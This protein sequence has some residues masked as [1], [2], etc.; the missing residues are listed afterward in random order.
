MCIRQ[1]QDRFS[2]RRPGG[3]WWYAV[4]VATFVLGV[5]C[6]GIASAAGP[7]WRPV[8]GQM[9][10]RWAKEVTPET[11][12]PE[13]PRPMMV[14]GQW[15]NLNGLWE[16]AM[17]PVDEKQRPDRFD[18]RILVPFGVESALSGVKKKVVETDR[19]WYRRT[20][21]VPDVWTG[22]RI[23][24]NF[25]AVDWETTIWVNGNEATHHRGGY[26]PFSVDI[27]D[28]LRASGPQEI[29]A[30]VWDPTDKGHQMRGKQQIIPEGFMYTPTSGIWQ[31][32]W[33]EP[34]SSSYIRSVYTEPDIDENC[35]WVTVDTVNTDDAFTV[36]TTTLLPGPGEMEGTMPV[37]VE[38]RAGQRLRIAL[39]DEPE[40]R[41]WSPR[42]PFLYD[43][44]VILKDRTGKPI[45]MV[46]SYFGMRKIAVGKD[47]HDVNRLFLNNK[48]LFQFGFLDQGW[49]PDGLYTAPTDEALRYDIETAKRL[50]ANMVRKHV[51]FEPQRFYYWCDKLGILVWQDMPSGV[52]SDK[53]KRQ[54]ELE[55]KRM[56]DA[57]RSHP[58]IVM[59]LPFN[60]GWG[61]FDAPR[62][63][64]WIKHYDPTRLVNHASGWAD[65]GDF[66]DVRDI[67]LYPE[68]GVAPILPN[69]AIVLGE[70]GGISMNVKGHL[71]GEEDGWGYS[72]IGD[73]PDLTNTYVRQINLLRP[74]I[75]AGLSAACYTQIADQEIECNGVMTYDREVLKLDAER[76]ATATQKL[77]GTPPVIETVLATSQQ[78]PQTW[79]YTTTEPAEN[80]HEPDFDDS[81]WKTGQA[82]FGYYDTPTYPTKL[83]DPATT[84]NSSDIWIRR[85]FDLDDTDFV[86]PHFL[87]FHDDSAEI[88]LNGK[89][90]L[91]LPHSAQFYRW[92]PMDEAAVMTLKK[93]GNSIAVH[94]SNEHHP[95]NIDVGIVDVLPAGREAER[96]PAE[97]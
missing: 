34:V 73:N 6:C 76:A 94:A 37:T 92:I 56:I 80:W 32:V 75:G 42:S 29:V 90:I 13:Y 97:R 62:I 22:H 49:W 47:E 12:L 69:R 11:V 48:P 72:G 38:S 70:F 8:E 20:F 15:K 9:M 25:G 44:Q 18:S 1:T 10:T 14:R 26:D 54:F 66:G 52:N 78:T 4:L 83:I 60:E 64:E 87:V 5:V 30:S 24:L 93:K 7:G 23:L 59:W 61:Q 36:E 35:V 86:A 77:Y 17:R 41:L 16:F 19:L 63:A 79:R 33:I 68:P 65:R 96:V 81:G 39:R 89:Q 71:W 55:L 82:G 58:S 95:Q 57:V 88:Y 67:H 84:W 85:S 43:L 21:D 40:T 46:D 28:M 91:N 51:K 50:G 74:M 31:T 45:D 53:L 27:T 3:A 2:I